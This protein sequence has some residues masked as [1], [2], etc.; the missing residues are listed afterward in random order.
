MRARSE[1]WRRSG[2]RIGFVPTM[3]A[4]HAG[5]L[6]LIRSAMRTCDRVVVSVFVNP[7]QFGPA[8]D[9]LRYPRPFARDRRLLAAEG[10]HAIFAPAV[11][12]MYP[13]GFASR[14][15]VT[16]PLVARLCAPFRPGH[17]SGVATVVVKL[18]E[19]VRPDVAVFGQKDA[20]QLAVIRRVVRDLGLPVRVVAHPI[21]RERDGLAL[22]SR[23]AYL[24]P[25]DRAAAPAVH[26]ALRTGRD[27]LRSGER[28]PGRVL[29]AVRRVLAAVPR[30][31]IQYVDL[32]NA[33]TLEPVTQARGPLLLAAA[34]FLG[35]TRLIDNLPVRTR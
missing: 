15:E 32:V 21:V 9:Y 1:R 8:E 31:R 33:E 35:S 24:S 7:I 22:S 26:R 10:A 30:L 12:S 6:A 17:F 11:H 25:A 27:L 19:A 2:L 4:L 13:A 28:R 3:G 16:G 5:H 14:I 29:A 34:V 18:F 20:Q 23:N